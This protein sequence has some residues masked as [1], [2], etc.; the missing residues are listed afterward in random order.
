MYSTFVVVNWLDIM[1]VIEPVVKSV[2]S[3]M[4]FTTGILML[5]FKIT[6]MMGHVL[7]SVAMGMLVR[8]CIML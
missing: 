6:F 8:S 5:T 7:M 2:M 3:L 4:I 1:L